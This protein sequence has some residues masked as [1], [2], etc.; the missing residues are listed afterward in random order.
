MATP[1]KAATALA[2]AIPPNQW[3]QI[4]QAERVNYATALPPRLSWKEGA[5]Y[6]CPEL[7]HRSLG[8]QPPSIVLGQRV[9][10]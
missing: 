10:R 3:A 5:P 1:K 8:N 7:Q 6:H 4:R 2:H 9:S